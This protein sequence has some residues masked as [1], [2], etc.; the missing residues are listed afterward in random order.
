MTILDNGA[1]PFARPVYIR[2]IMDCLNSLGVQPS[3]VL[4]RSGLAWQDVCDGQ[5][6]V[7]FS[8]FRRLIAHAIQCSGDPALGLIAGSMLQPYHTSVGIAAV[9][10]K[11]VGQGLQFWSRYAGLVFGGLEFELNNGPQW[12]TLRVKPIRPLCET[13]TFVMQSVVGAHCRLFEAMLGRRVEE[14]VVRLPDPPPMVTRAAWLNHAG[15][16]GFGHECLALQ[17]PTELLGSPCV[18][19]D[20]DAFL[21]AALASR[22]VDAELGHGAF[23]QRVQRVIL[24]RLASNPDLSEMGEVLGIPARTLVHRLAKAGVTYS[25]LKEDL[26]KSHASWYLQHTELSIEAIASQLGYPGSTNFCR[27]FKSWHRTSPAKMRDLFINGL[28]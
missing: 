3:T 5:H 1:M 27:K 7:D 18:S 23:V 2:S 9:T 11:N 17:L 25:G 14:L 22:K 13:H 16:V 6:T 24:E 10:S 15:Q 19:A 20:A 8:V 28:Q 21:D 12:S 4:S 26:R